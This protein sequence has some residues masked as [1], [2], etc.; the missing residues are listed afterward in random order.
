MIKLITPLQ[1]DKIAKLKAG[2]EVLLSGYIY[3]ARDAAHKR[4]IE[5]VDSN[6][7]LPFD[8]QNQV[9]FYVGPTP[10]KKDEVFGSSGPTTSMRMD[11]YTPRLLSLGLKGMIGKGYRSSNVID[12]IVQ[13]RALYLGAIGGAGAIL[14]SCVKSSEMIAFEDLGAEAI[15]KIYVEDLPLV[16]LIDC[17]GNDQYVIGQRDYLSSL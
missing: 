8:I 11:V 16:V 13:N 3:T 6:L 5:L 15:R 7:P 17:M 2:D 9:I 14:S 1:N 10:N 12:S 4:L